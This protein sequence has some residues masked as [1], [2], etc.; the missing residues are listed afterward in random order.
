MAPPPRRQ[1]AI[2]LTAFLLLACLQAWPLPVQLTTRL[3]GPPSGDTGVYVWNT[4]VFGRELLERGGSPYF[5][6]RIFSLDPQEDLSLHNYTPF[7]DLLALPFQ[8]WLGV[9]GAF[10]LVYLINVALAGFG[11][12]LLVRRLTGR[13]DA[14]FLSGVVFALSP[15][16]VARSAAHFSLIS[17]APLPFFVYWLD[18]AWSSGRVRDGLATGATLAWAAASDVYYAVYC[19]ML[20][21]LFVAS[22]C[23]VISPISARPTRHHLGRLVLDVAIAAIALVIGGIYVLGGGSIRL[24]SM[25]I[26]MHS[27][28]TPMLLLTLLVVARLLLAI[29]MHV[30]WLPAPITRSHVRVLAI[31]GVLATVL[32]SPTLYAVGRRVAEGRMVSAPVLWR[33]SAPGVDLAAVVAPNATHPLAPD[34]LTGWLT[35]LGGGF[36]ENVVSL[37]LVALVTIGWAWRRREFRPPRLWLAIAGGFTLLALGPFIHVA[38]LNT[39]IPTPW[40]LLRYLPIIGA[41]RMPSRFAIV[42]TMGVAVLF[43]L[44]VAAILARRPARRP[45]LVAALAAVMTVELWPVPRTLHAATVPA[46]Y[47]TIAADPR[48]VR[49]LELPFGIRDGLSSIGDYSAASQFHQ[50]FHGKAIIGGYLSRVSEERKRTYLRQPVRRALVT[51]SER[52]PLSPSLASQ[53]R[54]GAAAFVAQANL[55][56]V[57]VDLA[58]TTPELRAF[59]IQIF[60]LVKIDDG[61]GY[62]LYVPKG[63]G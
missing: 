15:F 20:G 55:G 46:I 17:A 34:A 9:V 28:Y 2:A 7:A 62:E 56:Y 24:A 13:D 40:A 44:A 1:N 10:N 52:Q 36:V 49:V 51:L 63:P 29:R 3:T 48:P 43:G 21:A 42:A 16:L 14:A 27:L 22:R 47:R 35:G 61:G 32:L 60:D 37:P 19:V 38:G 8:P 11:L 26:S 12:F 41:A 53:A 5:T 18:R 23:L 45:W 57:V 30:E 39:Y 31:A 50:T 54:R 25:S 6:S 33:S 4:W 59:A 58:R